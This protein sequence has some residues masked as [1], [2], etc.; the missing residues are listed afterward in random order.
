MPGPPWKEE[1][2][3]RLERPGEAGCVPRLA[4]V[5]VGSEMHGDD[6]AGV[7]AARALMPL[8]SDRLL[9]IDAGPAPENIT[10]ILRRFEP[11]F[12]LLIDAADMG[13]APGAVRWIEGQ[14][15]EGISGATH[16]LPL[17]MLARY[18]TEEL[19]CEVT[20]LGIQPRTIS[21]LTAAPSPEVRRA[22]EDI[23]EAISALYTNPA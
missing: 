10:G 7:L 3:R 20:L 11:D 17:N 2:H 18:L 21:P 12:I 1:L 8:G 4:V 13:E 16:S 14:D 23:A 5:G 22:V 19:G 15:A 6:A 9:V